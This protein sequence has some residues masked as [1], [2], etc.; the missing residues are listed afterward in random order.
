MYRE[1]KLMDGIS[2]RSEYADTIE[3]NTQRVKCKSGL[4][5]PT[6]TN[7]RTSVWTLNDICGFTHTNVRGKEKVLGEVGILFIGYNFD[8]VYLNI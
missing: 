6:T 1:V 8:K 5:S 4:L 3:A 7:H 2:D